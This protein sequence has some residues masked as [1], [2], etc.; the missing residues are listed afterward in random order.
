MDDIDLDILRLIQIDC[1]RPAGDIARAIGLSG[2]ATR[3]RLRRLEYVGAIRAQRAILDPQTLGL[4]MCAFLFIELDVK[5]DEC[6]FAA[7]MGRLP[8][9]Q[10]VHRITGSHGWLLKLRLSDAAALRT[11]VGRHIRPFFEARRIETVVVLETLKETTELALR[12][13]VHSPSLS[14]AT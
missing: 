6:A 11:V 1:R 10:E 9:V 4:S 7:E 8:M 12:G 5:A 14:L 3:D 13:P 2:S